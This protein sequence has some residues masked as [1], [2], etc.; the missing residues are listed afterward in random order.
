MGRFRSSLGSE[1]KKII[2][3]LLDE[4]FSYAKVA[5]IKGVSTSCIFGFVKRYKTNLYCGVQVRYV[6]AIVY[7]TILHVMSCLRALTFSHTLATASSF[8]TAPQCV[9]VHFVNLQHVHPI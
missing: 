2:L 8:L 6:C 5:D 1:S 7:V 3:K 9:K 4:E